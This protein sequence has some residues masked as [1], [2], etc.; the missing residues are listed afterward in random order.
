MLWK[1]VLISRTSLVFYMGKRRAGAFHESYQSYRKSMQALPI[2]RTGCATCIGLQFFLNV[3]RCTR[4]RGKCDGQTKNAGPG[5]L[6]RTRCV[7]YEQEGV[8]E[9]TRF[10]RRER[11]GVR[12]A[13]QPGNTESRRTRRLFGT[14]KPRQDVRAGVCTSKT[15]PGTD[16]DESAAG[17]DRIPVSRLCVGGD[18]PE[19]ADD[20]LLRYPLSATGKPDGTFRGGDPGKLR[21]AD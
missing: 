5:Q 17:A 6:Q 11:A 16:A 7:G 8:V 1:S 9:R 15:A 14:R 12:A 3:V 2:T 4:K 19:S 10:F 13:G 20:L 21:Y 18:R